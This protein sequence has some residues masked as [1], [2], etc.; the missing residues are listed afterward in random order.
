MPKPTKQKPKPNTNPIC[1]LCLA[2]G[3]TRRTSKHSTQPNGKQRYRCRAE[4]C[5]YTCTEGGAK[6]GGQLIGDKPL[7]KAERQK[8]Y[9]AKCAPGRSNPRKV[10]QI[11]SIVDGEVVAGEMMLKNPAM[12]QWGDL[13]TENGTN[14]RGWLEFKGVRY[15]ES[16]AET[17]DRAAVIELQE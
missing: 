9:K 5:P 8:R 13:L 1:P 3:I 7:T 11:F 10:W 4:G 16:K 15:A 17:A 6:P 2:N 12:A 14:W